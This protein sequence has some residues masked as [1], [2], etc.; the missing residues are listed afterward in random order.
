MFLIW[1]Q[2]SADVRFPFLFSFSLAYKILSAFSI[3][4]FSWNPWEIQRTLYNYCTN[5]RLT[6]L[7][8]LCWQRLSLSLSTSVVLMPSPLVTTNSHLYLRSRWR[9]QI[10]I[11]CL[12]KE[13]AV[14]INRD[15][16]AQ[17][18][19]VSLQISSV[20]I[21]VVWVSRAEKYQVCFTGRNV[22]LRNNSQQNTE[23]GFRHRGEN[24]SS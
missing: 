11:H 9:L 16:D 13:S 7:I 8:C 22:S 12:L 24:S 5:C 17:R 3:M 4:P 14:K 21:N 19:Y 23:V 1:R 15:R 18:G 10:W 6:R 2:T 20:W